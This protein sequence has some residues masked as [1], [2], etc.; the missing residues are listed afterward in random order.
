M[1]SPELVITVAV[2]VFGLVFWHV[3][4]TRTI[5]STGNV[6]PNQ[7]DFATSREA[8]PLLQG[9][10]LDAN[11]KGKHIESAP[12][13]IEHQRNSRDKIRLK[14]SLTQEIR[15]LP[16]SDE[17]E[18]EKV[19]EIISTAVNSKNKTVTNENIIENKVADILEAAPSTLIPSEHSQTTS[20]VDV[21]V[22]VVPSFPDVK[23][24]KLPPG[25]ENFPKAL[26]SLPTEC[27]IKDM[28]NATVVLEK[29]ALQGLRVVRF[30]HNKGCTF[31]I[32]KEIGSLIKLFIV[33]CSDTTITI[34]CKILTEHVEILRCERL[35]LNI[36]V[37]TE[38]L[39]ID[40]SRDVIIMCDKDSCRKVYHAGVQ[41]LQVCSE[42]TETCIIHDFRFPDDPLL[43]VE[44]GQ[45]PEEQQ[46]ITVI[47]GFDLKT[48]RVVVDANSDPLV[49]RTKLDDE[50]GKVRIPKKKKTGT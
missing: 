47:D 8:I 7:T 37:K 29:A 25:L 5:R 15:E 18:S 16:S 32:P 10:T 46:Y 9:K 44:P 1:S 40:L 41:Q 34:D 36:K 26:S 28:E 21:G 17:D 48:A 3:W 23:E 27:I 45:I 35:H 31:T 11:A 14:K 2:V 19:T 50:N 38:I 6:T 12:D 39:Q 42:D 4:R 33:E 43:D 24:Y 13:D 22:Q 30:L 20:T 49:P